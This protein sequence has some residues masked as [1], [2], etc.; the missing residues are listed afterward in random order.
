MENIE[1]AKA[2]IEKQENIMRLR[3]LLGA[4]DYIAIKY[5][6]GLLTE[7]EYAPHKAQRQVWRDV[8]NELENS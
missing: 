4:T 7:E 2:F 5:A 3:G 8:I 1:K 6:E